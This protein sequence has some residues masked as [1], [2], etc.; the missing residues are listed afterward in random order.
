MDYDDII[1]GLE[2]LGDPRI[3]PVVVLPE[4]GRFFD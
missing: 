3:K 2:A 4:K 1:A